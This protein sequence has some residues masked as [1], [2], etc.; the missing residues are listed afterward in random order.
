VRIGGNRKCPVCRKKFTADY[1]QAT[2]SI[3]CSRQ[4]K[5]AYKTVIVIND[6][7]IPFHDERAMALVFS[8]IEAVQPQEL[9]INGDWLDCYE[10][11]DFLKD[12]ARGKRLPDEVRQAVKYLRELRKLAPKALITFIDGNHEHRLHKYILRNAQ[13]LRGLRGLSIP[14]QLEFD[15]LNIAYIHCEADRFIDTFKPYCDS[16]LLVGHFNI[17]RNKSGYTASQL[18]D[19]YGTSIIQGHVHSV[20]SANKTIVDGKSV[21]AWENGCLCSLN[22][23]YCIPRK[24]MHAFSVILIPTTPGDHFFHVDQKLIINYSFFDG[25]RLWRG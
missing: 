17:S 23:S 13:A 19:Q 14:E 4:Y 15:A 9:V 2:C 5:R 22:P 7:H 16:R 6:T 21:M 11:S 8:Y 25:D 18:L 10:V 24:W 3:G 1:K 12:P 20:G